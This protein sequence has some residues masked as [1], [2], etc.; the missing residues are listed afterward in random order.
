M[1]PNSPKKSPTQSKASTN[2]LRL[3]PV[4][5]LQTNRDKVLEAPDD[6]L[7]REKQMKI[8]FY[9]GLKGSTSEDR[10]SFR[11]VMEPLP[12]IH[13]R[14]FSGP[15]NRF[16]NGLNKSRIKRNISRS[17]STLQNSVAL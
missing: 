16:M 1:G 9:R 17:T 6:D 14:T 13:S 2:A 3:L 10:L 8:L 4:N 5:L 11:T 15:D 7:D 12:M